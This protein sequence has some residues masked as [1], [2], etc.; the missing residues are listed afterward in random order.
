MKISGVVLAGGESRRFG[1]PK[2]FALH[3]G[4][5]FY[6]W[7]CESLQPHVDEIVIVTR[8]E[9][10]GEFR[11]YKIIADDSEFQGMGP[12]AGLYSAMNRGTADWY[13]VLA[14]DMPLMKSQTVKCLVKTALEEKQCD[15]VVLSIGDRV[16]PLAAMYRKSTVQKTLKSLLSQGK[17]K[18]QGFLDE[19]QVLYLDEQ[20]FEAGSSSF[21]NVNTPE[22]LARL[23]EEDEL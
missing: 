11:N 21:T 20:S 8:P 7:T 18:V 23:Q 1:A 14:C 9:F 3:N 4:K 5:Y 10:L 17:R 15:A 12:L 13:C 19:I 22:D 16:Q 6:E 2:A